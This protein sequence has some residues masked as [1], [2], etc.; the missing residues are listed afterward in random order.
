MDGTNKIA[1]SAPLACLKWQLKAAIR[2]LPPPYNINLASMLII[3]LF[4]CVS[5]LCIYWS[6]SFK[7]FLGVWMTRPMGEMGHLDAKL[8]L[9]KSILVF[10]PCFKAGFNSI[11]H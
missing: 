1:M 8:S 10:R 3:F 9:L 4:K 2:V 6:L 7:M 5:K 11:Y